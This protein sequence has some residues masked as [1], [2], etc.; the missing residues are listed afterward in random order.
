MISTPF[1]KNTKFYNEWVRCKNAVDGWSAQIES[2]EGP[3]IDEEEW[4]RAKERLADDAFKQEYKAKFLDEAATVF[5]SDKIDK[6][7][8]SDVLSKPKKG[9]Y[10]VAGADLGKR[11]DY[12]VITVMD[13]YSHEVVYFRRFKEVDWSLQQKRIISVCKKYNNAKLLI[14]STGK[15]DPVAEALQ[16]NGF[17]VDDFTFSAKGKQQLVEKLS[18]Y[19]DQEGLVL[20]D[21][22]QLIDELKSFGYRT[23]N[24][25]TGEPLKRPKYGPAPGMKDDCVDSLALAI[26][27]LNEPKRKD[28]EE[29]RARKAKR[30]KKRYHDY[31]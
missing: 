18:I 17:K 15:G 19:I 29:V 12:T 10:Y 9:H 26:W 31:E 13:K 24:K 30:H 20:P 25:R 7:V 1:G 16:H 27:H 28:P 11:Q 5:A 22:E 14:D 23:T 3:M 21:N 4:E 8:D 6:L 2:R